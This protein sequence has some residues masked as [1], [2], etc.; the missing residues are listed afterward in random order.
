MHEDLKW[1]I[2]DARV[3]YIITNMKILIFSYIS[4]P[5]IFLVS[6]KKTWEIGMSTNQSNA[7]FL[8]I[9]SHSKIQNHT[10]KMISIYLEA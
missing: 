3:G 2:Q 6:F 8:S 7:H 4:L 9:S 1:K 5:I 10:K